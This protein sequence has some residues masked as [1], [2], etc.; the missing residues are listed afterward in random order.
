MWKWF[1][2]WLIG[3]HVHWKHPQQS[4]SFC[5]RC[6]WVVDKGTGLRVAYRPEWLE[7]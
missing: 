7:S 2:C 4:V 1:L 6:G 5:Y 3:H